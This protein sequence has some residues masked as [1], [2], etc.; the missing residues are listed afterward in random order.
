M[1]ESLF[2]ALYSES[3]ADSNSMAAHTSPPSVAQSQA[4]PYDIGH[5]DDALRPPSAPGAYG[6]Q[7]S[8]PSMVTTS[9]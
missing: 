3:P 7:A 8:V 6:W 5:L 4:G 1:E 9:R 2:A